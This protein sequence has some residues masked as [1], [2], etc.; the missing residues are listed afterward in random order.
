MGKILTLQ[1]PGSLE[2]NPHL[3]LLVLLS[4]TQETTVLLK[5]KKVHRTEL[6]A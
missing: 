5:M 1:K 4:A 6:L 2:K 3:V